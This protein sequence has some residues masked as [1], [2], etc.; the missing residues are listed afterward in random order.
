[1][2]SRFSAGER[3]ASLIFFKPARTASFSIAYKGKTVCSV[4]NAL[5]S[6]RVM[7][8]I[9]P[10]I[11]A[12]FV[13]IRRDSRFNRRNEREFIPPAHAHADLVKSSEQGNEKRFIPPVENALIA[14][15]IMSHNVFSPKKYAVEN[16]Y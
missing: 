2:I 7:L 3:F 8:I 5:N 6:F 4:Q 15:L 16:L 14:V 10:L 12:R 1:M 13:L 11:F 9:L